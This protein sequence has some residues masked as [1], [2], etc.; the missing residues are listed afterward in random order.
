MRRLLPAV[1]LALLLSLLGAGT[2]LADGPVGATITLD[3]SQVTLGDRITVR[4]VVDADP[5]FSL[6]DP[7]FGRAIGDLEVLEAAPAI[8]TELPGGVIRTEYE[9]TVAG[10][11][12]G[13][14]RVPPLAFGYTEPNGL[15][16]VAR[17]PEQLVRVVSVIQDGEDA[18]TI[19]PLGPQL[20]VPGGVPI[21]ILIGAGVL[22]VLLLLALVALLVYLVRRAMDDPDARLL[23]WQRAVRDLDRLAEERL[24]EHGRMA[25]HYEGLARILRRY[26]Q[27]AY[28]LAA[29]QR[30][31]RELRLDMVRAGIDRYQALMIDEVL[32]ESEAVRFGGLRPSVARAGNAVRVATEVITAA[33]QPA[34][35][36]APV[37]PPRAGPRS[38]GAAGTAVR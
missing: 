11:R 25:A 28:G 12:L 20:D 24:A 4:I 16:G 14:Q 17:T 18:S 26:L 3:R 22:A 27:D 33:N 1:L 32:Q 34:E 19:K 10:F 30:T 23:P 38:D 2:V 5:G 29:T 31:P 21:G 35:P 15:R 36:E 7:S 37:E 6:D 9:Y 8:R 13:D